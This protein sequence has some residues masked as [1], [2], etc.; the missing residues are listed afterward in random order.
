MSFKHR[1]MLHGAALL[2]LALLLSAQALAQDQAKEPDLTV[3]SAVHEE[4]SVPPAPV[5]HRQ[6][7]ASELPAN[8][9]RDPSDEWLDRINRDID[10]K[11][12]ICRGC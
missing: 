6:P 10:R 3:G 12:Q 1:V 4:P 2:S 11:L 7:Q 9:A 5:G 8:A